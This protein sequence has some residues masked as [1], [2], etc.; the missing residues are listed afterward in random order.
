MY[1]VISTKPG[2]AMDELA[3]ELAVTLETTLKTIDRDLA[4]DTIDYD[5]G[6]VQVSLTYNRG[7]D[8]EW[9]KRDFIQVNVN[10]DSVPAI[11]RDVF[12]RVYDRCMH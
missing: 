3:Q 2:K 12:N 10:C 4:L 8:T 11:F 7:K 5:R 9:V 1:T 6:I